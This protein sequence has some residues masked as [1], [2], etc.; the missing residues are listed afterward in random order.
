MKIIYGDYLIKGNEVV[1]YSFLV[2][3]ILIIL[4]A[5]YATYKEIKHET[6]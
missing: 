3:I 2:V 5:I 4:F 6:K 1:F